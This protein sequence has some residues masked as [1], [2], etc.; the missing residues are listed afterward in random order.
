MA[1]GK[2]RHAKTKTTKA[3][4]VAVRQADAIEG[5]ATNG[6]GGVQA[7]QHRIPHK[8]VAVK[9]RR[10]GGQGGDNVPDSTA[11]A[12]ARSKAGAVAVAMALQSGGDDT[13][14][15]GVRHPTATA[16]I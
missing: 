7:S 6:S 4:A 11:K 15:S 2:A 10:K 14:A 13:N 3:I 9:G 8:A 16:S 12:T 5:E 1:G